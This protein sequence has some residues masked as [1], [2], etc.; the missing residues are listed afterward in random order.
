GIIKVIGKKW[1]VA[2]V[3]LATGVLSYGGISLFIIFFIMYPMALNMHKEGNVSKLLMPAE[4]ALGSFTFS[5]TSPGSPQ[6]PNIIPVTF[7]GTPATSGM[8][9]GWIAASLLCVL[10]I[11]YLMWREK[12]LAAKGIVFEAFD[13]LAAVT[14][15]RKLPSFAISIFPSIAI[16]VLLNVVKLN[17]VWTMFVGILLSIILMWKYIP[18]KE[19]LQVI[20]DGSANCAIVLL[21]TAA[22]VGYAG[23]VMLLPEFPQIVEAVKNMSM[24]PYLFVAVATAI[25]S[26][27]CASASGG[28]SVTYGAL[29]PTFMGL[30]IPLE[31]VHRVSVMAA[32]SIDTL[33]HCPAVINLLNVTKTTHKEVYG[34]IFV[35]TVLIPT[36]V[37]FGVLVPFVIF[38]Y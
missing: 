15:E 11:A 38:M 16:I 5:M 24:N 2:G 27:A 33:P 26:S 28:L 37:V 21:N 1:V 13:E 34:N 22:I 14:H 31:L 3:A 4:I 9:P 35:V 30:G 32:G 25:L 20:N 8:L 36:M 17:I 10:G 18:I 6:V 29:T 7:L 23:G 19:W 12:K